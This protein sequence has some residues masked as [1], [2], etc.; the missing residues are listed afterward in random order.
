MNLPLPLV[1]ASEGGFGLNFNIFESNIIN[2]AIVIACLWKFLPSF[3]GGILE[4]RRALILSDLKDAE[5]RLAKATAS[6]ATAQQDLGQ[7]QKKADQIRAEGKERAQ[8]IRLEIEKRTI[9][10]MARIKQSSSNDLESEAARVTT[11]LRRQAAQLA[12]DKALS[13][14]PGKLDDQAQAR[15]IEQA[16]QSMGNA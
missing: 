14:L 5:E 12:I 15:F 9:E 13:N 3:L 16:I 6:L 7:A 8:S 10:D 4:R 11:L 2:L 1:M